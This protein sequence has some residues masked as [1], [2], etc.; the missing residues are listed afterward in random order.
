MNQD[1]LPEIQVATD[2]LE[3]RI[4]ITEG[5]VVQLKEAVA[6][7]KLLLRSLRKA[8]AA[9]NPKRAS[10]KKRSIQKKTAVATSAN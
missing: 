4:A 1:L 3:S 2:A 5:E 6:A 8:I 10:S 7:K 9:F